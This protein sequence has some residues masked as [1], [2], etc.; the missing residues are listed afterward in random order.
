MKGEGKRKGRERKERKREGEKRER[1]R[2]KG[3][4]VFRRSELVKPRSK[5]QGLYSKR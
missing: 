3:K 4:S 5:V 2:E 1:K